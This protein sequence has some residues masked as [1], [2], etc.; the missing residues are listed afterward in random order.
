MRQQ[1]QRCQIPNSVLYLLWIYLAQFSRYDHG[2]TK[3][4]GRQTD[5]SKYRISGSWLAIAVR[6]SYV[7][8]VA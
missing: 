1:Y 3:D 2:R 7:Y 8:N 4:D 6:G 5:D